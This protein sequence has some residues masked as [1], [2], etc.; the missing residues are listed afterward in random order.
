MTDEIKNPY[1]DMPN[2]VL[3]EHLKQIGAVVKEKKLDV[4]QYFSSPLSEEDKNRIKNYDTQTAKVKE[5]SEAASAKDLS[6][7]ETKLSQASID[8]LVN[9]IRKVDPDAPLAPILESKFNNLEKLDIL[10]GTG[11]IVSH[12]VDQIATI[13]KE[14]G[15]KD[16]GGEGTQQTFSKPKEGETGEAIITEMIPKKKE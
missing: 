9:D 3:T 6:E 4:T 1:P 11:S 8:S 10:R 2:D 13:K 12:Y 16:K 15:K 5:L 7:T 14:V